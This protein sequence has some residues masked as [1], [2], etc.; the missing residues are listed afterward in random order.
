MLWLTGRSTND[1]CSTTQ[2]ALIHGLLERGMAVTFVTQADDLL[3]AL[4][5]MP[6]VRNRAWE[7]LV[8]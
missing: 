1:L 5:L 6:H 4:L 7:A 8:Q 2:Q 3:A